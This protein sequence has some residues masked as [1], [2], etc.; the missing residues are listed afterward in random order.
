MSRTVGTKGVAFV[1]LAALGGCA[2]MEQDPL[3]QTDNPYRRPATGQYTSTAWSRQ[4]GVAGYPDTQV[5]SGGGYAPSTTRPRRTPVIDDE[6]DAQIVQTSHSA[7]VKSSDEQTRTLAESTLVKTPRASQKTETPAK[8]KTKPAAKP[9][10]EDEDEGDETGCST[11]CHRPAH[12]PRGET[13]SETK[14]ATKSEP[15]GE[16]QV[17][18]VDKVSPTVSPAPRTLPARVL[19]PD[20]EP[21]V[22]ASPAN[23]AVC[24]TPCGAAGSLRLVNSKRIT[25]SYE[26]KDGSPVGAS[27]TV[28]VWGT[29]DMRNWKKYEAVDLNGWKKSDGLEKGPPKYVIE[30]EDEGLFGFTMRPANPSAKDRPLVGELPQVWVAVDRTAPTVQLLGTE[31]NTLSATPVLTV[32]WSAQDKNMSA[33]PI[34]V[35]YAQQSDGPWWPIAAGLPNTGRYEWNLPASAPQSLYVRVQ[36]DDL[37]GNTGTAQTPSPLLITRQAAA[38]PVR[39]IERVSLTEAHTVSAPP[40]SQPADLPQ[41]LP[42]SELSRPTVLILSVEAAR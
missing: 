34:T 18:A 24:S 4:R 10:D 32:R 33:R 39:D 28:E 41:A 2:G 36:A 12:E 14:S 19:G 23:A 27:G 29:R 11:T 26:V 31:L 1:V 6:D 15:K 17:V 20:A 38:S 16:V 22:P 9:R 42:V 13:K 7:P 35:S 8:P 37:M 21:A 30:V 25:F 5:A 40:V 3:A